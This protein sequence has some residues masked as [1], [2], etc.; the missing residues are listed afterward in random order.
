MYNLTYLLLPTEHV[1]IYVFIWRKIFLF[2]ISYVHPELSFFD[3][4]DKENVVTLT[5][6][7]NE[8]Q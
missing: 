1:C 7:N 4:R 5:N 6:A 2:I 3:A 8:K